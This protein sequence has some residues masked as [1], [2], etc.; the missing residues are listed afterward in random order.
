MKRVSRILLWTGI[1]VATLLLVAFYAIVQPGGDGVLGAIRTPDGSE[2]VV[3]QTCNWSLEPYTVSF[4]MRSPD[5]KWGWCYIDHE[6]TR[7]RNVEVS[8]DEDLDQIVVTE[9]GTR[10]AVLDRQTQ[11]F[12][13]DNGSIRR[14]VNA[15]QS[16]RAPTFTR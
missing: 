2:Y 14:D 11:N 10:H 5:G 13:I 7:W 1:S 9:Q 16:E 4:Y 12:C 3:E 6:A 15:P 8:Y